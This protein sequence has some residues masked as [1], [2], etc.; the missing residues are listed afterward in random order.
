MRKFLILCLMLATTL[1]YAQDTEKPTIEDLLNVSFLGDVSYSPDG[2]Q[3]AFRKTTPN[4]ENNIYSKDLFLYRIDDAEIR[5]LTTNEASDTYPVWSPDGSQLAFLSDRRGGT[6]IWL[7]DMAGG[8]GKQITDLPQGVS[9]PVFSKD[10]KKLAF[11]ATEGEYVAPDDPEVYTKL[12]DPDSWERL[13]VADLETGQVKMLSKN[14][15]LFLDMDWSPDGREIA[16]A[17]DTVGTDAISEDHFIGLMDAETGDLELITEGETQNNHPRF[18][19]DGNYLAWI[20]CRGKPYGAYLT[21]T[22]VYV[23]KMNTRG[24]QNISGPTQINIGGSGALST[25]PVVWDNDNETLYFYGTTGPFSH[26]Y[27]SDISTKEVKQ[28]TDFGGELH[29]HAINPITKKVA[30]VGS[31]IEKPYELYLADFGSAGAEQL[32]HY[33][34]WW[35]KYPLTQGEHFEYRSTD[36]FVARGW[37]IK[38]WHF[39][40][41]HKYPLVIDLHGGPASRWGNAWGSRYLWHIWA[42]EGYAIFLANPRGSTGY[43]ERYLRGNFEDFGGGDLE[44]VLIGVNRLVN[45]GIA[46]ENNLFVTGY[47]YGGFLTNA[48]ISQTDRFSAAVSIAGGFDYVSNWAQTNPILMEVYYGHPWNHWEAYMR[49][50][51]NRAGRINTP[52]LLIHPKEDQAVHYMQSVEFFSFLQKRGI[53]SELRLYPGEGHSINK[54]EH[55]RDYLQRVWE[56]FEKY[57]K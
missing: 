16:V 37:L 46:D 1:V 8:E 15:W 12:E 47:S 51:A 9:H 38:P 6:Q 25:Y 10:G 57:R 2:S 14:P 26:I 19:P 17:V 7:M 20:G 30:F 22:D 41:D 40:R 36:G 29:A 3:I 44:D 33:N 32:T 18:S 55:K 53:D 45:Q 56:W 48:A 21:M 11:L 28:V 50:P 42:S 24:I 35:E 23:Y 39:K 43:G 5:Q 4:T 49:S 27:Q 31:R 54:I 34:D 13:W 52:T